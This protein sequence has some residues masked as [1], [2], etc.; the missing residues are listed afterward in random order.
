MKTLYLEC[1]MGAAGDMLMAAL[2]ELMS[3][4]EKQD[5]L[6]TMNRLFPGV[7]IQPRQAVTCGITGTHMDVTVR[8]EEEHSHDVA[9]GCGHDHD[10]IHEH[11]HEHDHSH[12]HDHHHDH[13][14]DHGHTHH[15]TA[16]ADIAA[17][18][19]ALDAPAEVK[20]AAK[21]IYA[22]IAD[23]EAKAHGMPVEKIHFH[24]VGALDAVADVTGACLAVHMLRPDHI[25]AS[26]VHLGSGQVR[27]AHG[28]VPVPAP[29]TAHLLEGVLCYTGDIR[30]E[31]CTPTGA[32]LLTHFAESFGPMPVMS[33]EKTGYGVGKK[34][35]PAAN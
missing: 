9:L 20:D 5:F 27:C 24:E 4:S 19:D 32:A 12:A 1:N 15:H 28:I 30:G 6:E 26:P 22:R 14:H 13:D 23:A 7:E 33:L 16:P 34:E 21:S 2:Y 17:L 18:L 31:L 3:E 25:T 29:A 11:H 8:G 10:H 35:F